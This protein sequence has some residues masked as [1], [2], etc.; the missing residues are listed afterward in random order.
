MYK[1]HIQ[2]STLIWLLDLFLDCLNQSNIKIKF[3]KFKSLISLTLFNFLHLCFFFQISNIA[4]HLFLYT[5][6][7][8]HQAPDRFDLKLF[9][10]KFLILLELH[11]LKIRA[12]L[13][14]K[15]GKGFYTLKFDESSYTP[16]FAI[17]FKM[18]RL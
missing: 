14:H 18:F 2:T 10:L 15:N 12:F 13:Q 4:H 16:Q 8:W 11:Y 7:Y 17:F 1:Y 6:L 3:K 9:L 5:Y